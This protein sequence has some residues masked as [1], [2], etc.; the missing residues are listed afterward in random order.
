MPACARGGT[1]EHDSG[2][3]DGE[4]V[5]AELTMRN[6]NL[7]EWRINPFVLVVFWLVIKCT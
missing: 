2:P 5:P 1:S 6:F 4:V 3:T 7:V